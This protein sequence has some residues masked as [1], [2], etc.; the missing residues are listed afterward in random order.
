[1]IYYLTKIFASKEK[2]LPTKYGM[3]F[4]WY[5]VGQLTNNFRPA[6]QPRLAWHGIQQNFSK[7]W[8]IL[9]TILLNTEF[10]MRLWLLTSLFGMIFVRGF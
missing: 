1:M 8:L 5:K 6:Q 3:P 10:P 7:P 2:T 4:A 9:T